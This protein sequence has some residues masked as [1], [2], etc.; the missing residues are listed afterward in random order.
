MSGSKFKSFFGFDYFDTV[1]K[2]YDE[3]I[4]NM[5]TGEPY[6]FESMDDEEVSVQQEMRKLAK[7]YGK[8]TSKNI[9]VNFVQSSN[10]PQKE[11]KYVKQHNNL[12]KLNDNTYQIN[13]NPVNEEYL[14]NDAKLEHNL[15]HVLYQS[16][17]SIAYKQLKKWTSGKQG[18][19]KIVSEEAA[20]VIYG[21]LEDHRVNHAWSQNSVGLSN[22]IDNCQ[23]K[24]RGELPQKK[25][26]DP[27]T[28]LWYAY[29]G[30]LTELVGTPFDGV[31][32][33][34]DKVEFT[35]ERG[36]LALAKDYFFNTFL[37][38]YKN[39]EQKQQ[40]PKGGGKNPPP[41]GGGKNPPKGGDC[42][43]GNG[44][45]PETPGIINVLKSIDSINSN[46]NAIS[47][48]WASKDGGDKNPDLEKWIDSHQPQGK[49]G[50]SGKGKA[51]GKGGE[52][53]DQK[54][55][56]D[57]DKD[58][59]GGG[60]SG[61]SWTNLNDKELEE[62][63][64]SGKKR[65]EDV[66]KKLRQHGMIRDP[67]LKEQEINLD[68][69]RFDLIERPKTRDPFQVNPQLASELTN[70][71]RRVKGITREMLDEEGEEL[72][73]DTFI[74]NIPA[75]M[76]DNEMWY[77]EQPESGFHILISAD[78]SGSMSGYP[79]K[80]LRDT[81]A[82]FKASL[83]KL[84]HVKVS[85]MAWGGGYK[86]GVS[87]HKEMEDINHFECASGYNGTPEKEAL[88]Y[89]TTWLA[90][91]S[92]PGKL[93]LFCSDMGFS[94]DLAMDE[95]KKAKELGINVFGVMFTSDHESIRKE[96]DE[97][98]GAGQYAIINDQK[99]GSANLVNSIS[100]YV[101]RHMLSAR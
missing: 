20:K 75:V 8:I 34:F 69:E 80:C 19:N 81:A 30:K 11:S 49:G 48:H 88:W 7:T 95:I 51:K 82:T 40:P 87:I 38:W 56:Q 2:T 3:P 100:K 97:L 15:A 78:T 16:P 85:M 47:D 53:K 12:T 77:S 91:K 64:K 28:A 66:R 22:D 98:F 29:N 5:M 33:L 42:G 58:G 26:K 101:T 21:M 84:P 55:K 1:A 25:V 63:K 79:L 57:V 24:L 13:L 27:I 52:S 70:Q 65:I 76:K 60:G 32:D 37:P 71:W 50:N 99:N 90:Q 54:P 59:T 14:T 31:I 35:D 68:P 83:N 62:L 6:D 86:V 45:L 39:E 43:G 9:Q 74:Q 94:K 18:Q 93:M 96:C 89:G 67:T 36:S 44:N 61:K 92:E 73:I 41:K 23:A 4:I 17:F 72:D 10:D 46:H